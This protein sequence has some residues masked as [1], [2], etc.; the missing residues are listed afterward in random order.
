MAIVEWKKDDTVAV[1]IMNNGGNEN[2]PEWAA[3]MMAVYNEIEADE[4][5]TALVLTSSDPKNFC[6]GVDLNWVAEHMQAGDWEA[7]SKWLYGNGEVFRALMMAPFPTIAAINGHAF[8]N[9]AML[10]GCCDFR[11]MR[12][13]RGYMCL[14]EID[15]GIQIAP[16]ML[17]WMSTIIPDHLFKRMLLSGD[18]IG[19]VELEK[20]NVIIKACE[21]AEKTLEEAIAFAKTFQKSRKNMREMK[22]RA[23]KHIIDKMEKEDPEYFDYK[24]ERVKQ[25]Q[26]PIF[27]ATP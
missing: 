12:A 22:I 24:P 21:S 26:L 9:G 2:N 15:T 7:I 18:R 14:P 16:S 4:E 5:V 20:N 11:F 25:G 23:Y 1:M 8:G 27:M 19:A 10:A 6:L 13:D 3:A 17:E